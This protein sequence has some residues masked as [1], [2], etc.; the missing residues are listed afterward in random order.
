MAESGER[1]E[2]ILLASVTGLLQRSPPMA[3]SQRCVI[4]KEFMSE[5]SALEEVFLWQV[6]YHFFTQ[7]SSASHLLGQQIKKI[8]DRERRWLKEAG[9]QAAHHSLFRKL[10]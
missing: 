8:A 9:T 6:A 2:V 7:L 10:G 3:R 1:Q 4:S 5:F